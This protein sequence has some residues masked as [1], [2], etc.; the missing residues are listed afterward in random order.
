MPE[1]PLIYPNNVCKSKIPSWD[2]KFFP[3]C[4][5]PT[6]LSSIILFKSSA[7]SCIRTIFFFSSAISS[8]PE[9]FF[10]SSSLNSFICQ[11]SVYIVLIRTSLFLLSLNYPPFVSNTCLEFFFIALVSISDYILICVCGSLP[12]HNKLH[13]PSVSLNLLTWYL[14]RGNLSPLIFVYKEGI[15]LNNY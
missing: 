15:D 9:Y 14:T 13:E 6:C 1:L 2:F 11:V 10:S 12:S 8:A 3:A 5:N 4:R 7:C